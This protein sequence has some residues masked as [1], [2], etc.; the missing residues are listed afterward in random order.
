MSQGGSILFKV[1][2]SSF[3][4]RNDSSR[5]IVPGNF[6][7]YAIGGAYN[8]EQLILSFTRSSTLNAGQTWTIPTG[9]YS[10]PNTTSSP[11]GFYIASI[12]V[13]AQSQTNVSKNF[14][15]A[16]DNRQINVALSNNTTSGTEE[17]NPTLSWTYYASHSMSVSGTFSN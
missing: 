5:N 4:I 11:Q 10:Y 3:S 16:M 1:T 8:D 13:E 6:Y 9:T 12:R 17:V 7:I 2:L 14:A 15:L